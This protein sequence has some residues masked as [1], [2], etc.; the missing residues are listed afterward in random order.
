MKQTHYLLT[1]LLG[2]ACASVAAQQEPNLSRSVTVERD[3]QPTIQHDGK[4]PVNPVR[5]EEDIPAA[6]VQYSDNATPLQTSF[7]LYPMGAVDTK[8]ST[9]SAPDGTL[10]GAAG[11]CGTRLDFMYR[12]RDKKSVTMDLYAKHD[13]RW[14][15]RTWSDSRLGMRFNKQFAACTLYFGLEGANTFYTRYGHYFEGDGRL[16]VRSFG[17][18]M[19]ADKQNRW[20][21]GAHIGVRSAQGSTFQY[22]IQTGY[23]A[24]ILPSAVAEHHVRTQINLAWQGERHHAGARISVHN[25]FLSLDSLKQTIADTLYNARH[26]IRFEPYYEY[27]GDKIRLHAGVNIDLNIGKGKMMSGSNNI[28]FAPSPNVTFEYR[29]LPSWLILYAEAQGRFALGTLQDYY[30]VNPYLGTYTGIVSHHVSGYTPVDAALGFKIKPTACLLLDIHARCAYRMNQQVTIAPDIDMPTDY[31]LD[32]LDFFYSDWQQWTVGAEITYH[33]QDIIH[34]LLN[35][36]YHKWIQEKI[37]GGIHP[38]IAYSP[39]AVYDRPAWDARLRVDANINSKW[40]LYSDNIF[41]GSRT[42]LTYTG[43]QTLKPTIDL[44]L[45]VGYNINR[46]L[47]CYLQANN[48][49]NRYNDLYYGYQTQ[50][51]QV[52]AGVKWNF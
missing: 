29:I 17:E 8:F 7:N 50:G 25:A 48:L 12:V 4:L 41:G 26:G 16:S 5:L 10:E 43:E 32:D 27:V 30:D 22:Q 39:T 45:G 44:R 2:A 24:Y 31:P 19:P 20:E 23:N 36:H 33:Y 34:I 11:Y 35:G 14:G 18:M 49:L 46:W 28:S 37:E 13:A 38:E 51:I 15:R 6:Q 52:M 40:S 47:G 1:L 9:P 42:A 21:A 3:F